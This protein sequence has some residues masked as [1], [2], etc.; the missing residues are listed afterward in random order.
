[1]SCVIRLRATAE[2][3]S[4]PR[5]RGTAPND[6]S[7]PRGAWVLHAEPLDSLLGRRETPQRCLG[8]ELSFVGREQVVAVS[9]GELRGS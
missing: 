9:G 5:A 4:R 6:R 2:Y 1:M 8:R 7:P 3:L